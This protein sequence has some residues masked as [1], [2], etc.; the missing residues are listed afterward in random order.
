VSVRSEW[1]FFSAFVELS[2]FDIRGLSSSA[3]ASEMAGIKGQ[4][5]KLESPFVFKSQRVRSSR[6]R[7]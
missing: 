1:H 3:V 6:Y 4:K 5:G 2:V 7:R